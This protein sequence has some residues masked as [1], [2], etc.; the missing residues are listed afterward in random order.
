MNGEDWKNDRKA[1]VEIMCSIKSPPP[2]PKRSN[3]YEINV[4][5]LREKI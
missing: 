1:L 3:N 4:E 2:R 5:K